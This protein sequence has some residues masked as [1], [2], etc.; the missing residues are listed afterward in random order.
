MDVASVVAVDCTD[1]F[2]HKVRERVEGLGVS[3]FRFVLNK[4]EQE[5]E[6]RYAA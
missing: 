6:V 4:P 3:D 2:A 5:K 1:E